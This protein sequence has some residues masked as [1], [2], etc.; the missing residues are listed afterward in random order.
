MERFLR[1]I[2]KWIKVSYRKLYIVWVSLCNKKKIYI[3]IY[4]CKCIEKGEKRG[5]LSCC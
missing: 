2:F 5:V 1:Y 3:Y 4:I